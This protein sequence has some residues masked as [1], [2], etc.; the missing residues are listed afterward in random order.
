MTTTRFLQLTLLILLLSGCTS[1][2]YGVREETWRTMS[3]T[4]H[5]QAI[6]AYKERQVAYQRGSEER[7][8]R[9]QLELQ[10]LQQWQADEDAR[11]NARVIAIYQSGNRYGD[12]LRIRLQGGY[13]LHQ[14]RIAYYQPVVFTISAG[15]TRLIPVH[16]HSGQIVRL[17]VAYLNGRLFIDGSAQQTGL[18]AQLT[19]DTGWGFGQIYTG[20]FSRN[21]LQLQDVEAYVEIVDTRKHDLRRAKLPAIVVR[22][23][24]QRKHYAVARVEHQPSQRQQPANDRLSRSDDRIE[25]SVEQARLPQHLR[26]AEKQPTR[27]AP[28]QSRTTNVAR[29]APAPMRTSGLRSAQEPAFSVRVKTAPQKSMPEAAT[30]T[31][32]TRPEKTA[33]RQTPQTTKS[34]NGKDKSEVH[35]KEKDQNENMQAKDERLQ[36]K[37]QNEEPTRRDKRENS[38]T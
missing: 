29:P 6:D 21:S 25:R 30:K 20:L 11:H 13:M 28:Q 16:A 22:R 37:G 15:E 14:G 10:R 3:E 35:N 2:V 27:S 12:L 7:I 26:T 31:A 1:T 18:C 23:E 17:Q 38:K 24:V 36:D 8:S 9:Q 19:F 4:E 32:Q 34:K 33:P 5:L